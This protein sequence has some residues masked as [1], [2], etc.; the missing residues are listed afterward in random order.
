VRALPTEMGKNEA[1]KG[2][3]GKREAGGRKLE[4]PDPLEA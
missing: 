3:S 2:E 1:S 4:D